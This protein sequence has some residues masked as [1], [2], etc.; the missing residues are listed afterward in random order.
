MKDEKIDIYLLS[1]LFV[2]VLGGCK[3]ETES[4][5]VTAS[6]MYYA[7]IPDKYNTGA[8]ENT[9]F[10]HLDEEGLINGVYIKIDTRSDKLYIFTSY[11]PKGIP[12][13]PAEVTIENYDFSDANFKV[14]NPDRYDEEKVITFKNC[15]FKGFANCGPY[16]DNKVSVIFDH[17]SFGGGVN[18]VN[19]K[20]NWCKIGHFPTD[21][22]NPLKNFTAQNCYI[23]DLC[24][25]GN[26]KGTHIDG[27]Q[28]Y[29]RGTTVGGNILIDNVRFEIPSIYYEGN[30]SAV[31]ACVMFQLEYGNVENCTFSNLICN[32]GGKWYPIYYKKTKCKQDSDLYKK[33]ESFAERNC[34]LKNVKV[35]NNFGTI[36]YPTEHYE[37]GNIENVEHF[38]KLYVSSIFSDENGKIHVIC[39]NDTSIDK[40]LTVQTD[41]G[42]YTFEMP[43]YPSNW[44][45]GGEID[46]KVNPD[47]SLVDSNG[48]SY[49]TYRFVDLPID[50]DCMLDS[51]SGF[52]RCLDGD[53][54]I[55][56]IS[57]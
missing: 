21:A 47:E 5:N 34:C 29:G 52:I 11:I 3:A 8:D 33:G 13:P 19:I 37:D 45:L 26:D 24:C 22:M 36:F 56:N 49:K 44:A 25:E 16:D 54:E 12:Q 15:K 43:H 38:D 4:E 40:V 57:L 50:I 46:K 42:E 28:I 1:I 14:Y 35:S 55:L 10:N 23:Y 20:M 53:E 18:E 7:A 51:A 31:N 48:R 2:I 30:K 39:T 6:K 17:C 32:G 27:F 41:G 9:S